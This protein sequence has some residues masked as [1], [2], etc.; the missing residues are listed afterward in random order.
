MEAVRG[1]V[2]IFSGI[3]QFQPRNRIPNGTREHGSKDGAAL[4]AIF[5]LPPMWPGF[6]SWHLCHMWVEFVNVVAGSFLCSE[7]FF[8]G[9]SCFP[10]SLKTDISKFQFNQESGERR[11]T[12]W[13]CYLQIVIYLFYLFIWV[14]N[15]SPFF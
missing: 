4:R 15:S 9:Y 5:R 10:L 14:T 1:W 12:M 6:K 8:S 7:R 11:T 2:W 13:M 3:A